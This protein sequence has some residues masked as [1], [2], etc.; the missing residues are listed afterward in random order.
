MLDGWR[1]I[2]IL[3]VLFDHVTM[4]IRGAYPAPWTQLGQHGVT[5]F[6]VLSGYLITARLVEAPINLKSFYTRRFFRLMPAAWTFLAVLWLLSRATGKP[7][8]TPAEIASCVFFYRNMTTVGGWGLAGHS[9]SLSLEE[10]FYLVWPCCLLLAGTTRSRWIAAGGACAVAIYRWHFW[11]HYNR[12]GQ[13]IESQVRADA[14]LVGCLLALLLADAGMRTRLSRAMRLL[15]LPAVIALPVCFAVFHELPPLIESASI[16]VLIGAVVLRPEA[17]GA[18]VLGVAPLAWLGRI[19]YSVYLWQELFVHMTRGPAALPL[20]CIGLPCCAL[21][22]YYLIE[23][24]CIRFARKLEKTQAAHRR[25]FQN[26]TPNPLT[27]QTVVERRLA[28]TLRQS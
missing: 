12:F 9:W 6:F 23:Q 22:S 16:A 2:A 10:Q 11:A 27:K 26:S 28:R 1:G 24:P 8:T 25:L 3:L 4:A 13:N 15:T 7:L 18:H 21:A 19:S 20:L 14:L 17:S 5:I